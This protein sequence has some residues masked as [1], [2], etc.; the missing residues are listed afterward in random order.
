M[1]TKGLRELLDEYLAAI[2]EATAAFM[3]ATEAL[4]ESP[5]SWPDPTPAREPWSSPVA[6]DCFDIIPAGWTIDVRHNIPYPHTS[7]VPREYWGQRHVGVD[8]NRGG[9]NQD[10]GLPLYAV[11]SGMIE[12]VGGNS[13]WGNVINLRTHC[14]RVV[15]YAHLDRVN[16]VAGQAVERGRKI[17]TL[18]NAGGRF[19]AHLHIEVCVT[20][21]LTTQPLIWHG[22]KG[23]ANILRHY[24][25]PESCYE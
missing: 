10:L 19:E 3:D 24:I 9:Q 1:L 22:D 12:Y 11:A 23:E 20:D 18:G 21:I 15:R 6:P 8:I 5:T 17:G 13:S 4:T 16:V 14:G 7:T 25:D 2:D